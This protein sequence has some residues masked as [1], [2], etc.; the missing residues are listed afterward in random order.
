MERLN[1]SNQTDL[2]LYDRE[3]EALRME[4]SMV[5]EN[6]LK[7]ECSHV[8]VTGGEPL[9]QQESLIPLLR[10]LRHRSFSIEV[11]TNGT[12]KPNE[13]IVSLVNQWNV[14][15]KLESSGNSLY[16]REK[17]SCFELFN[18]LNSWYKFVISSDKDL[19]EVESLA[20]KYNV[21]PERLILMPEATDPEILQEKSSQLIKFCEKKGYRFSTR[22]QIL[23]FG[24]KRAR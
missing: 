3:K 20:R 23:L 19:D 16:S 22:L 18:E 15:P 9:I 24:N 7:F 5:Q 14:S 1:V 12:V 13:D 10:N 17:G 6:I 2:T 11:E 8:V 21:K 4:V